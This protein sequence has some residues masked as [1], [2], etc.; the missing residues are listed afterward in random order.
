MMRHH[1]NQPPGGGWFW[2]C[3]QQTV[4]T[5]TAGGWTQHSH[6]HRQ[7]RQRC[8][9]YR[10]RIGVSLAGSI[11]AL[12]F[13]YT[14]MILLLPTLTGGAEVSIFASRMYQEDENTN[15]VVAAFDEDPTIGASSSHAP[16]PRTV[17]A[18]TGYCFGRP[19]CTSSSRK[20]TAIQFEFDPDDLIPPG[21]T[22]A[23]AQID[24]VVGGEFCQNLAQLQAAT[25]LLYGH[26]S[27]LSA[28]L[29][30]SV[31]GD[32]SLRT[33]TNAQLS[34][35]GIK[36]AADLLLVSDGDT[37][38]SGEIRDIVQEIIDDPAWGP[39]STTMVFLNGIKE[40]RARARARAHESERKKER[41][42]ERR[43]HDMHYVT[44]LSV[45]IEVHLC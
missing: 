43:E 32:L 42:K 11:G 25:I 36:L 20:L 24:F 8:Q 38:P 26:K 34:A 17:G 44:L 12:G 14:C 19:C 15:S 27:A 1:A 21:A 29:D 31:L 37:Y 45:M 2:H 39:Q 33:P 3:M 41:K 7:N 10:H 23:T 30:A 40:E 22:I 28:K 9:S 5:K 16:M 6:Q 13:V 35:S 18:Y 4:H